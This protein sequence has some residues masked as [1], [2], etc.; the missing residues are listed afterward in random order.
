[1]TTSSTNANK[2]PSALQSFL[3]G[4]VAGV[5]SRTMVSPLERLKILY[6]VQFVT[7]FEVK[8]K[9]TSQWDSLKLMYREEGWR[10]FFK[11]NGAN[12]IRVL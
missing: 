10:S 11:G 3:G 1:M 8:A 7:G 2:K 6:Q 12:C 9:Y 5:V 4:G